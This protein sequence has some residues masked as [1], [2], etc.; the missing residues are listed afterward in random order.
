MQTMASR[1]RLAFKL[2]NIIGLIVVMESVACSYNVQCACHT[3]QYNHCFVYP[4]PIL[5]L[6]F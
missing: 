6:S 2:I 3:R 4:F 5:I 1:H